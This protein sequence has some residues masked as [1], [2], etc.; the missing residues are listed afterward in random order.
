MDKKILSGIVV[1]IVF[2]MLAASAIPVSAL[3]DYAGSDQP[4]V[5]ESINHD[6]NINKFESISGYGIIAR[7]ISLMTDTNNIPADGISTSTIIA[8]LKDRKGNDVK[9]EDVIINFETTKGTLSADSAVTDHDGKAIVTL[10]SSTERGTAIVK[11]TSDS[12]LIPDIM[13][14]KFVEVAH[15]ISLIAD[16][17]EIPANG[18]SA[19]TIVA[20]LKDR[21]GN[22]VKIEDVVINFKTTK[23]TLSA[24]SAVTNADGRATVTLISDTQRGTAV[25]KATSDIVLSPEITKVKFMKVASDEDNPNAEI[26]SYSGNFGDI[27]II[28]YGK[29][30]ITFSEVLEEGQMQ[31]F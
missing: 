6:D 29:L 5:E 7:R 31:F 4:A 20:Q 2:F 16:P 15:E 13:K 22:D 1:A 25:I 9:V 17:E 14:V 30:Y 23:G 18:I 28:N 8:Q 27:N 10:T 24:S 26:P 11:A 21:N 3:E 12:V 19:S